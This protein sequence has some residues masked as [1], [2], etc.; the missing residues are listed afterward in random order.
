MKLKI[1][2]LE[3]FGRA[4]VPERIR[5]H[6]RG[7]LLKAGITEVPYR[8]FGALFYV[9]LVITYLIYFYKV[10]PLLQTRDINMLLFL[11]ITFIVW[12]LI[13]IGIA[14]FFILAIYSYLDIIIYNRTKKIEDV[15]EDFLSFVS[16][17]LKGG[18]SLDKALWEAVKPEFGV[19][20]KEIQITSKKVATGEDVEDALREFTQK[21][22]SPMTRRSFD[23]IIEGVKSG[24]EIATLID[25]VVDNI[26]ETKLLNAD[27]V[28]TNTTYVIF[29]SFIVVI[30][31]PA[32]FALS[33][34]FLV[35]LQTLSGKIGFG[36]AKSA[37]TLPINIQNLTI[38]LDEFVLFSRIAVCVVAFCSSMI[39]SEIT[40]GDIKGGLKYIPIYMIAALFSYSFFSITL[41]SLFG[42]LFF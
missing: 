6:L 39:V 38:T 2:F 11:L 41:K 24:G 3:E 20:S 1:L 32:L 25:K 22:N 19:L 30:I 15:L 34:Q 16:E 28:A 4:F 33:N 9:S 29:I 10:Y 8:L 17:N 42:G 21:Y 23:L 27:M 12:F 31:A 26:R 13:Q 14:A 7:Y 5:P 37:V 18:M 35:I 36:L 40:R